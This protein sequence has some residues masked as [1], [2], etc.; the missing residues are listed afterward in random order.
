MDLPE[1]VQELPTTNFLM[2]GPEAYLQKREEIQVED[3]HDIGD[4]ETEHKPSHENATLPTPF[5][6]LP[7][8]KQS[9]RVNNQ[10]ME[11]NQKVRGDRVRGNNKR[12][13][14]EKVRSPRLF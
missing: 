10:K 8:A 9:S 12:I 3:E 14:S 1:D 7:L 6:P 11:T 2:N 5:S 4:V 13:P